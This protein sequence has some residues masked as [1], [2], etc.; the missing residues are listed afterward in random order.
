MS[1]HPLV[2][3]VMGSQSDYEVFSSAIEILLVLE[4]PYEAR[5]LSA[6]RT[7]DQLFE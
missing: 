2:G 1:E 3:V 5:V 4:I 6:H 7:P